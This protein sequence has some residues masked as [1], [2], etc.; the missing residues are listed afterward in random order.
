MPTATVYGGAQFGLVSETSATGLVVG[1]ATWNGTSE[2]A[3][4][5]DHIG[6]AVGF[7]VYNAKK[8]VT[9][10]GII[11]AKGTGLV[12]TIGS[13]IALANTTYNTRTRNSEGLG[14]TP[15]ANA[16][17]IITGN[18]ISPTQTGFEGGSMSGIYLPFVDTSSPV[19]VT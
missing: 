13:A 11:A 14:V 10:D 8:D 7:A 9:C 2:T 4:L 3:E 16:S 5:P 19:T 17:I 12:D 15:T 18:S 1:S 6:V